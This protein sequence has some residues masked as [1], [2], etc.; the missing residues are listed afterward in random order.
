MNGIT[1]QNSNTFTSLDN[2]NYTVFVVSAD[3][4]EPVKKDFSIFKINNFISPNGDGKNDKWKLKLTGYKNVIIQ[5]FDRNAK[6]LKEAQVDDEFIWD[7]K[8]NGFPLASDSYWY[9]IALNDK[10]SI[11]GYL[12]IKNK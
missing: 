11:T 6:L 3:N 4:C 10:E 1:W 9:R 12:T 8:N 7:G 2:G 5:I